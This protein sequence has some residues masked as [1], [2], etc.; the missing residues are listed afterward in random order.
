MARIFV[1]NIGIYF[2]P[3]VTS[4]A[5]RTLPGFSPNIPYPLFTK[6]MPRL[7]TGAGPS[8]AP[9]SPAIPLMVWKG[10]AVL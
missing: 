6:I 7:I 1:V 9:P 5:S 10:R 2:D 4:N 3:A 8:T